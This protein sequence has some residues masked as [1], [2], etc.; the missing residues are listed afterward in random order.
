[1]ERT[2][3]PP[4]TL[5]VEPTIHPEAFIAPGARVMGDVRLAAGASVWYNAVLRGDIN[6]ISIG[7]RSNIQDGCIL[8]LENEKPCIVGNDVTVGHGAI[9]HGC[10]VEDGCLIGMGA[11]ILSGAVIGRGSVIAAGALVREGALVAPFSLMAGLPAKRVRQLDE[12][13]YETHL[14]WA[15]KYVKLAGIHEERGAKRVER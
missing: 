3:L 10:V 14:K 9:L 5:T 6:Y 13:T 2:D 15:A 4:R 8:H 1:M 7:E 11:I 12:S